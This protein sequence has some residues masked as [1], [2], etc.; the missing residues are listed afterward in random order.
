[1]TSNSSIG[2]PK[3]GAI[4]RDSRLARHFVA[5]ADTL[6]DD[7]DVADLLDRLV[8]SCLDLLDV[9]AAGLLLVD[10]MGHLQLVAS[11]SEATRVVEIYQ[12]ESQEGPCLEAFRTG[13]PVAVGSGEELHRRWPSFAESASSEG[14]QAVHAYPMRLRDT[15][16]GALNLFGSGSSAMSVEDMEIAQSLADVA[17]IGI[18]QQRSLHRAELVTEQLQAALN[19]RIVIEQAKGVLAEYGH[20]DME[21]AFNALRSYARDGNVKLGVAAQ[22]L[23]RREIS[24]HQVFGDQVH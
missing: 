10:P 12:L 20:V 11:S 4:T 23:V 8:L 6:V 14:F 15:T 1:V 22:H 16:I 21:S 19:S 18:L 7:Y 9:T 3:G 17:T 13:R 2:H 24:P 5:L